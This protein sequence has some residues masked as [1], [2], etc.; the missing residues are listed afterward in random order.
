MR[1]IFHHANW[2]PVLGPRV[3]LCCGRVQQGH[4]LGLALLSPGMEG[5]RR[6]GGGMLGRLSM[7]PCGEDCMW[8]G[9]A[10]LLAAQAARGNLPDD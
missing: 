3:G 4:R 9:F 8:E 5:W 6:C 10:G 2:V 1:Q 7:C